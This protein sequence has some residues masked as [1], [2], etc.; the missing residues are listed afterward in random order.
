MG[1]APATHLAPMGGNQDA[2]GVARNQTLL[3]IRPQKEMFCDPLELPDEVIA[4]QEQGRL[5][6]FAGAGV[7]MGPPSNLPGF[8]DLAAGIVKNTKHSVRKPYDEFLG[9]MVTD[10][11]QVH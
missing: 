7:S 2:F 4:A 5:V 11:V 6:I 8:G 10:G 1:R 9:D 3:E